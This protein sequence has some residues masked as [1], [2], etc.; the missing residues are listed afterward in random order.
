MP[1]LGADARGADVVRAALA[2]SVERL[3]R[4]DAGLRLAPDEKTV[5]DARV[6]VRRLRSDLR[7]FAGL[8]ERG[9]AGGLRGRLRWL[10][11]GLSSARDADVLLVRLRRAALRLPE[12][13]R[14]RARTVCE[15]FVALRAAAYRHMGEML[16]DPRYA[17]LLAE[18]VEGARRPPLSARADE[19]ARA[20][21]EPLIAG[22]WKTLRKAV[23]GRTRPPADGELHRIRIEAKRVRYAAEALTPVGGRPARRLARA[24]ERLQAILG[25]HH[26]AVQAY[27]QL[28]RHASGAETAFL[29]G[30]LAALEQAAARDAR[31]RWFRAWRR[32]KR[33][34]ADLRE[35]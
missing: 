10:G 17:A 30:E 12:A 33:R 35:R 7:S 3:V 25:D 6:A 24:V 16:R 5:H 32:A 1:P 11:D 13:D 14:A 4:C 28:R 34:W 31:R 18:L 15:P 29:A 8:L 19:P 9:W 2:A 22:A 21:V 23:R 26:D 27:A 20:L